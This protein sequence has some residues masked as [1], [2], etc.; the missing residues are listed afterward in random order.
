MDASTIRFTP[1]GRSS[2]ALAGEFAATCWSIRRLNASRVY[3]SSVSICTLRMT[4][5]G[6]SSGRQ[7]QGSLLQRGAVARELE[8]GPAVLGLAP[9][10]L[11]RA[12]DELQLRLVAGWEIDAEDAW[13]VV[14]EIELLSLLVHDGEETPQM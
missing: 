9:E 5:I 2:A 13:I 7:R 1:S 8:H 11:H 14:A 10:P 4:S 12:E 6:V 3:A